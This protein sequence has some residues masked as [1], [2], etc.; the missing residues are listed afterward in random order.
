MGDAVNLCD[1]FTQSKF[2][3]GFFK[4]RPKK[5][6]TNFITLS[7]LKGLVEKKI[8]VVTGQMK[9]VCTL[10]VMYVLDKIYLSIYFIYA[11]KINYFKI[12]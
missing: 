5:F 9:Y 7:C 10:I 2:S 6:Y 3:T 8:K 1:F 4:T 12:V 11:T